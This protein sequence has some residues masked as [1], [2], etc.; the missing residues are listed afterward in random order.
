MQSRRK[1]GG[2]TPRQDETCST[3]P[4]KH[5]QRHTKKTNKRGLL[6]STLHCQA[7]KTS[8]RQTIKYI[9]RIRQ[10]PRPDRFSQHQGCRLLYVQSRHPLS[11]SRRKKS[12]WYRRQHPYI[13]KGHTFGSIRPTARVTEVWANRK[14]RQHEFRKVSPYVSPNCTRSP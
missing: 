13:L 2:S 11:T 6:L 9:D 12:A 7:S 4:T 10:P 3:S 14:R 8:L 5:T 1:N